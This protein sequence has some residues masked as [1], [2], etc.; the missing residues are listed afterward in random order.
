LFDACNQEQD[1]ADTVHS[2]IPYTSHSYQSEFAKA[3]QQDV[4]RVKFAFG[5]VA[6]YTFLVI[7]EWSAVALGVRVTVAIAGAHR[8]PRLRT[9]AT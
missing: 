8:H 6:V 9:Y 7:S 1:N 5:A 2:F 3:V 4:S